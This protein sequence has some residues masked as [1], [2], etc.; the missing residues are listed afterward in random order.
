MSLSALKDEFAATPRRFPRFSRKTSPWDSKSPI[1]EELF[2]VERLESHVR[3]LALAQPVASRTARGRPL[4][5]RL[6]D[7]GAV[8]LAT[9]QLIVKEINGGRAITPAAEWL[10]DNY[11]LVEKQIHQIQME[12]PPGYYRQ[13]PKLITGPFA[14]YPRVF[15]I[16]CAFVAHTDSCFDAEI[17]TSAI[18]AYQSVQPLTIGELWAVSITLQI[19]LIENLRRLAQEVTVDRSARR[20][21]DAAADRLLGVREQAAEPASIVFAGRDAQPLEEAFAVQLVHRLRD[22]DPKFTPALTWLDARLSQQNHTADS[23]VRAVHRNQ[24]AANVTMR[25]IVM[26]LRVISEVDWKELF[27]RFCLVDGALALNGAFTDMDF[28]TRTLYRAAVEELARGSDHSELDIALLA[29]A[30]ARKARPELAELEQMRRGDPGYSLLAG[31]RPAFERAIGFRNSR[32]WPAQLTAK[33]GFDAYAAA[34]VIVSAGLLAAP[35]LALSRLGVGFAQLGLLA[36]LGAIPA[37]DASVALINRAIAFFLRATPLPGMELRDGV[38]PALRT[39][40][41]VPTLLTTRE[42][43]AEQVERL[44][45]HHLASPEGDLHF[46]LLS[47]WV[48]ADTERAEGDA[49]LVACARDGI[50]ALN[51]RYGPAPAGPRFLLLHRRRVWNESERRWIGWERKRG[52]LHELNRL[53]RGATD[54]TFIAR[55]GGAGSILPENVKYIVTLDSDTRLPRDSVRKLIG[56]MAHPLNRPRLD[57]ALGRVVEGYGILQPRVTPSLPVGDEGSLYQRLFSS[58]SGIDPYAA[59]VSDVYQDMLGEGSYAGKGIYDLDVFETALAGRAPESTLLSHD[60][61]EGTFARAGFA[62]D[63]EVVEQ[64][65]TR[66]DV[67]ALRHHRWARGDWQLL[68]WILGFAP[69]GDSAQGL[70]RDIPQVGRWKMIDNLRRTLSAPTG[71]LAL[72]LAWTLPL[73]PALVWTA[74]VLATI[75]TPTL[76]PVISAIPSRSPGVALSDHLRSLAGDL[77][78]AAMVSAFNIAFL[79]DQACLMGDAIGRTLWRLF[80]NRRHLLEWTPAAQCTARR[81]LDMRGFFTRMSGATGVAAAALLA[82]L[83]S[84]H[85]A[86]PLAAPFAALWAFSPVLARYVSLPHRPESRARASRDE[87]RALRRIARA[88]WRFF[89][90]FVTKEDHGLPPDNFQENPAPALAHRTSPTNI[91]LYLL[92]IASARDF[93][94][95]GATQAIERLEAT[96][97]SMT[98][99]ARYRGHFYNWYDTADLAALEPRYVSSVDSGNLAGHLIAV[100][101][102][103]REWRRAPIADDA[104]RAGVADTLALAGEQ[105]ALLRLGPAL[106]TVTQRRFEDSLAAV[107]KRLDEAPAKPLALQLP[108]LAGEAEALLDL[109]RAIQ[110]ER[111]D[112]SAADLLYWSQASLAAIQAHRREFAFAGEIASSRHARLV[113][114][115]TSFRAMAMAMEFDFL[116]DHERKLLSIGY[117]ISEAALDAS[118]YDLLASEARLASFFAIAKGDIPARHWFRLGRAATP[119]AHG[120]AL[121]SWSGSMFEYLMPPLVM[122]APIGSLLEQT[123]RL[124]VRRQISYAAKLGLPWGISESAYNARDL[125]L[126]YQYSNFGVPSL[127]LKRGLEENKVIAPYATALATMVD[128]SAA[129]ANFGRLSAMGA[130]GRFGFYEAVDFT[131]TRVREGARFA[132]VRAFMAHHQGMTIVAIANAVLGGLM[133]ERF[134]A[135][136]MIQATELLLQERVP[137]EVATTLPWAAEVKSA[138]HASDADP[139]GGRRLTSPHQVPPAS[140]LLSNGRYAVMLTAAGSGYSRWGDIAITRWREDATRDDSGAYIFLRDMRGG[141]VWSAG[142]Q[143][144]GAEPDAYCVD[145]NEDRVKFSRKDGSLTTTLEALVSAEDDSEV[146]RVSISNAGAQSRDIEVTSY[147][148]LALGPQSADV[149]HPAFAKLFVETEYLADVGAILATRRRRTPDEPEIWAAHLSV[150]NGEAVGAPEFETDRARFLGRG[151][152]VRAPLAMAAAGP[153][154][155]SCGTVLDPIFAL[156][157]RLVIAPGATVH[158]AFW[159]MAAETREALLDHIDKHRDA[160]AYARATTLA[161][162]QAQVQLHHLGVKPGQA[163]RYQ[164]L[165]SHV[166]FAGRAMRPA[167]DTIRQGSGPQSGLWPHGI[168]GD[169]PIVLLRIAEIENLSA[170]REILQAHQYWRMKM[171]AVDLVILNEHESSYAE[172]LQKAIETLVRASQR[173]PAPGAERLGG[174]VFVVRADLIG[175]DASRLLVSAARVVMAAQQGSL[176]DQLDRVAESRAS[177]ASPIRLFA[178]PRVALAKP[179][180]ALAKQDAAFAKPDLEFFNGLGGFGDDGR[181]YVTILGPGQSTPAPWINVIANAAFGFQTATDGGGYTWSGNSRENQLTPWCNDPVGDPPGE[182]FYLRDDDSGDVWSPT[183][184]PIRLDGATYLARHGRGYSRFELEAHGVSA[185][186][187]QFAPLAGSIKISRLRLTNRTNRTRHISVTAFVE[188]TLCAARSASLGFVETEIDAATGAIF[189]RNPWNMTFGSRVAFADMRGAQTEWT[190]D[191]RAFIGRNATLANPAALASA[192]T[193]SNTVG[194]ALDPCA[195]MR[196]RISLPPDGAAEV[197]FFLGDA[198]SREAARATIRTFRD[199]D[200]DAIE[201]DIARFWDETL[202]AV[203][204]RTPDRAMDLMLNGWLLYQTLACRVWARS[205]FYQAS[206]AYGF[207]DQLQDGM[208]LAAAR[209]DLTRAHL[210]RAAARQFVEG[211]VQHWWLP[212]SGQGVRTKISD[213]RPWLA[214]AVAHYVETTQDLSVLDESLP[215][216][217]GAPLEPGET[218]RFFTPAISGKAA[219]LFEHCALALDH[220]LALGSHGLPLMGTGDWND[221]MNRVGEKG[222]GES[223]WLAWFLHTTLMNFAPLAEARGETSRAK[224]WREHALSLQASLEREAWDGEWYKRAYFDDGAPLGSETNAECRIDSIAQSWA[225]LSGAAPPER[226]AR[227]MAA[228]DR[229]LIKK[230]DGLALLF[231]PPFD[232]PARDPGYIKA[233]PPGVRENGG[234][235]THAATWSVMAFA[236]LG[237]GD[238]AGAL[239]SML[240]P[241][242]H[243]LSDAEVE[244]YKVEPYVVS[245]DIYSEPPHVGRGGWTWYT[246]SA[247]WLQRAGV[248]SVLGLRFRGATLLIDPCVPKAWDRFEADLRY[249]SAHYAIFVENPNGVCRG[250]VSARLDGIEI[251]ERPLR[252]ALLDDGRRRRVDVQLG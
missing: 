211:D 212:R 247:G 73:E 218:D 100:A 158:V 146:R 227:A 173:R 67:G 26:S 93:G 77:R 8:L 193:L 154:G 151:Q 104:C 174:R 106:Q 135:E 127:G 178:K 204:V 25:N 202:G 12:L 81:R 137:R 142:F 241:I 68:P 136:P 128:P 62:S 87:A 170:A 41:A 123:D 217:E 194:A 252:V 1:R 21:A 188:W 124:I 89:E 150:A 198:E 245:A 84:P 20:D 78:I 237:D 79:A 101:N 251:V 110:L 250:V 223:V 3:S 230:D 243:A 187:L 208:A 149:A 126:T 44:E 238:K 116:F 115:E 141:A 121:I 46:A 244:R 181:E 39:L 17:L 186:L 5:P 35:M 95:I 224:T 214:F 125:D 61:F 185:D 167:S 179:H 7:N 38:P 210:L 180:A 48:D 163:G 86:W 16:V 192:A 6:A 63:V 183:A 23:V 200:L 182:A 92:A 82:A 90:V 153:L 51:R 114:L 191:R 65:P 189:A 175:A 29:A 107:T 80:V 225:V 166:I 195:A 235:Y 111:G 152:G 216:L 249:K 138:A 120:S 85:G 161:W 139:S 220:S 226:A 132:V 9:Y 27:E 50:D 113:A 229:Q 234:Q 13:L 222:E 184:R 221:G 83:L 108:E 236:A 14:G 75:V 33:L 242:N 34:I 160:A 2:S 140:Q 129:V 49:D 55:D 246:G 102:A 70:A 169:L 205:A 15:G 28:A 168:S 11:H 105:A 47:D 88:T 248:E 145:F 76:I 74:F 197:V 203:V 60:L 232:T 10:V 52:K 40:V 172:D 228:L 43:I 122:R 176:S 112:A 162:T 97:A 66:Y 165:A 109:A 239:F 32:L 69:K 201:A 36:A 144:T 4:A 134:H 155:N 147:C 31:G 45:I 99:L 157:R 196:A 213:D 207:R 133:R 57:A 94:W 19:V 103:C 233:Y 56:K 231:T 117:L 199:A 171:L 118:C 148:E 98:R 22:Q 130:R 209:P 64:F 42:D 58:A 18:N 24:G 37:I 190:G 215:F 177:P 119:V 219:T 59:A 72:A 91:G 156:R 53:L 206:G 143:P 96:L 54:T 71:A 240:N 164:R 159:T 131:P 30:E